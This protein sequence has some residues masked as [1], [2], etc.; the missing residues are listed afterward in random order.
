MPDFLFFASAERG[1]AQCNE[2]HRKIFFVRYC[3]VSY[4]IELKFCEQVPG[5]RGH[6]V[7]EFR[8]NLS[9]NKTV[10]IIFVILSKRVNN[11]FC[12]LAR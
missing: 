6:R 12:N 9:K 11:F 5:R 10:K 1:G 4:R 7:T 3:F 8:V 2:A